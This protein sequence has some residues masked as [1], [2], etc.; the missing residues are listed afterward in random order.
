MHESLLGCEATLH[1]LG[2][3]V[4]E[5]ES[6]FFGEIA[7]LFIAPQLGEDP[8]LMPF[9]LQFLVNSTLLSASLKDQSHCLRPSSHER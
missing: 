2:L 8:F 1:F 5:H 3:Q 9:F 7:I 4:K 6:L